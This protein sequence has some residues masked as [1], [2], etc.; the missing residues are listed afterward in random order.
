MKK[1]VIS[2]IIII[3]L[4]GAL[5]YQHTRL[6]RI[7]SDRDRLSANISALTNSH[8]FYKTRDSLNITSIEMLT[9]QLSEYK[10]IHRED[11]ELIRKLRLRPGRIEAV[12]K[13]VTETAYSIQLPVKD[14]VRIIRHRPDTV[15]NFVYCTPYIDLNGI[16]R[17]DSV[18]IQLKSYDTLM[19]VIHRV[20]RK[21]WFIR[22]GT[23]SIRQEVFSTNPHSVITYSEIIRLGR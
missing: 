21:F 1:T 7:R 16:I 8:R 13:N 22:Y 19:Q 9:F 15:K 10:R 12:G 2:L 5:Y 18:S 23:K 14:T 17:N 4:S 20:P 11:Y 6:R 3:T